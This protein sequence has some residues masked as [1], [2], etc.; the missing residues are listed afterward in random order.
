[1]DEET[2]AKG[3]KIVLVLLVVYVFFLYPGILLTIGVV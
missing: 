2:A 1:M 3:M